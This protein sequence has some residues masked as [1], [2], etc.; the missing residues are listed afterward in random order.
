MQESILNGRLEPAGVVEGFSV[1]IG[2]S[3]SFCPRHLSLPVT[4]YF[5]NLSDDN[6]PSPYLVSAACQPVCFSH[7]LSFCC[8]L[9]VSVM[10]V[11]VCVVCGVVGVWCEC[12]YFRIWCSVYCHY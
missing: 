3:G 7:L 10:C 6:A 1:D 9:V 4:A 5:F 2:A 11:C 12:L 8:L